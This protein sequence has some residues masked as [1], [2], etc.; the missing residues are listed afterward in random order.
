MKGIVLWNEITAREEEKQML[1]NVK[2]SAYYYNS[3]LSIEYDL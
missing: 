2:N 1:L 3:Y